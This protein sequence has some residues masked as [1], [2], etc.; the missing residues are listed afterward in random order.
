MKVVLFAL[1]VLGAI[2]AVADHANCPPGS[3]D[4]FGDG[5][6]CEWQAP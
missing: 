3:R 1:L 4:V 2:A 5:S 6:V